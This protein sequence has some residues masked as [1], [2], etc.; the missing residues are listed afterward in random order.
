MLPS[1]VNCNLNQNLDKLKVKSLLSITPLPD[2]VLPQ[3]GKFPGMVPIFLMMITLFCD[4]DC[5]N[6]KVTEKLV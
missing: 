6:W 5:H 4:C 2:I 3:S 1:L